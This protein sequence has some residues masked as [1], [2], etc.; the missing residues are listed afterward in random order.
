MKMPK[1]ILLVMQLLLLQIS[2]SAQ[3]QWYQN[4]DGNN[5]YPNGTSAISIQS[6]NASTFIATYLWTINNDE[7]TWKISKTNMSGVEEKTLFITGTAAQV[8]VKVGKD[9]T[10]FALKKDYPVGANP[11]F[12]VYKLDANLV[13]KKHQVISLPGDF[14]IINL[15]AFE[16]DPA[17]N[18]YFA[19]DG[20][21]P[22]AYGHQP[23]SFVLKTD[24]NLVTKWKWI[25]STETSFKRL[26][27]DKYGMVSVLADFYTFFP[28]VHLTRISV[29]GQQ[30]RRFTIETDPGRFTLSSSL[31]DRDNILIYGSKTADETDQEMYLYKFSRQLEKIVYRRTHFRA[32]N[33]QINDLKADDAGNIF[34]IVAQF[35]TEGQLYFKISKMKTN[36]GTISWNHSIL[37]SEDSCNLVK[38]VLSD[39][40]RFY[41]V[42]WKQSNNYF[43]KGFALRIRKNG[44]N[45][46]NMAAPDSVNFQRLHWLSD[47]IMD[48]NN[49][50]IAIG[51]T[52][53]LDTITYYSSYLRAFAARFSENN[54]EES[55]RP[56]A[57]TTVTVTKNADEEKEAI[58]LTSKLVVYPNPVTEQ[59]KVTGLDTDGY[60]RIF[61]YNMQGAQLYKQTINGNS[62]LIDV[63]SLPEGVYL[64]VL[65]SS[66]TMKERNLKFVV[67]R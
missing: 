44:H 8:E 2:I 60:D 62:A 45:P 5:Q 66:V 59:L 36:T 4:Q 43:S 52:S 38:L 22:G 3:M 50:L 28:D 30:V 39:N 21:Y 7:Y 24:K 23:A 65:K 9:K 12:T 13:V 33:L 58:Q 31:D 29:N 16:T 47:G 57:E 64:L 26:H 63:N 34:S 15:N 14:S 10:I 1:P 53:D 67:R 35:T 55:G 40:D 56:G 17:N 37:F 48:Y 41:A 32:A 61:V 18:V 27:V 6:F 42:G 51:G 19:G 49:R 54:C 11:V 25:D 46:E 20:Q